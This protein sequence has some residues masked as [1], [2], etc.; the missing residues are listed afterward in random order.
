MLP[1]L[2]KGH[3]PAWAIPRCRQ[4]KFVVA[5]DILPAK[6]CLQNFFRALLKFAVAVVV[7]MDK[8][9]LQA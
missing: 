9:L 3:T 8:L 6:F 1:E 5:A 4:K 7:A 2:G